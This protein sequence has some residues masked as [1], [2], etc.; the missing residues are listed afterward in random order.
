MSTVSCMMPIEYNYD[1]V[2]NGFI[3]KDEALILGLLKSFGRCSME[4]L[5]KGAGL[6]IKRCQKIIDRF[7]AL[8]KVERHNDELLF[9]PKPQEF[10]VLM[11][12]A[13]ASP[14]AFSC[15]ET[16]RSLP[17]PKSTTLATVTNTALKSSAVTKAVETAK[18][19]EVEAS[20]TVIVNDEQLVMPSDTESISPVHYQADLP[21][22]VPVSYLPVSPMDATATVVTET[23]AAG[24]ITPIGSA[25][26]TSTEAQQNNTSAKPVEPLASDAPSVSASAL[27]TP[28]QADAESMASV[29]TAVESSSNSDNDSLPSASA[30]EPTYVP[31][32]AVVPAGSNLPSASTSATVVQPI[33]TQFTWNRPRDVKEVEN[34]ILSLD[35]VEYAHLFEDPLVNLH[36]SACYFFDQYE[37]KDWMIKQEPIKNWH[38]VLHRALASG[39][40]SAGKP[41]GWAI[42][43]HTVTDQLKAEV[44]VQRALHPQRQQPQLLDLSSQVQ[45]L[46]S[47]PQASQGQYV[48]QSS[49]SAQANFT[50]PKSGLISSQALSNK[51]ALYRVGGA[52]INA[53]P[54]PDCLTASSAANDRGS[55]DYCAVDPL[56]PSKV[57]MR[58]KR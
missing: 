38:S 46:Y 20:V 13:A 29:S 22:A 33:A 27:I 40:N 49:F 35:R 36:A 37:A 55:S 9:V 14:S 1:A 28:T 42:I 39:T 26:A 23:V 2:N 16:V 58:P 12:A 48:Q 8:E 5:H 45:P 7:I 53:C 4:T 11:Q 31:A 6:T 32:V 15:S 54:Q 56:P 43:R 10:S 41:L 50:Q 19:V 24:Q 18:A 17:L 47:Q 57:A 21:A 52:Q 25:V 34:Y 30:A 44:R 51:S 3:N